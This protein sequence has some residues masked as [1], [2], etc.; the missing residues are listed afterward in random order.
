MRARLNARLRTSRARGRIMA[1]YSVSQAAAAAGRDRSSIRRAIAA[2]RISAVRD[3]A[4]NEWRIDPA[5]LHRVYPPAHAPGAHQGDAPSRPSDSDAR[6]AVAEAR[7]V[8]AMD[9]IADLR[10]RLD[11]AT[12]QLSEAL[13]QVRLLADGRPAPAPAPVTPRRAWWP[14]R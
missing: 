1:T 2:G 6:L 3:A 14:W 10:R 7:L 8:D 9:Q 5:E 4:T 11:T 13:A 12:A